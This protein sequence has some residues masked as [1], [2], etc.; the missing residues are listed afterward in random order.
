MLIQ[1]KLSY[2]VAKNLVVLV[3][4]HKH[5]F[6]NCRKFMQCSK[7]KN[8][9]L[10]NTH[11]N[12]TFLYSN[13]QPKIIEKTSTYVFQ[14]FRAKKHNNKYIRKRAEN[15]KKRMVSIKTKNDSFS[16]VFFVMNRVF[17]HAI[18]TFLLVISDLVPDCL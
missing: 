10:K 1:S 9:N 3:T 13:I 4:N 12:A 5:S 15:H 8:R 2:I 7:K 16:S 11:T 14:S 6:Q 18:L 17:V